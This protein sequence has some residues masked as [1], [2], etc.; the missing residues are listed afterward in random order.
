MALRLATAY[1]AIFFFVGLYLPF[2][3]VWLGHRGM[4]PSEVG[5]LLG[6][7]PW[8]R[9]IASP[10]AGRW[11]DRTGRGHRL[12]IVLALAV[13]LDLLLFQLSQGFWTLLLLTTILGLVHAPIIP[14]VDGIT[15]GAEAHGTLNY[16]RVR[17]WGSVAF[18]AASWI[19]G[20]LLELH[21]EEIIVWLMVSAAVLTMLASSALPAP[22]RNASDDTTPQQPSKTTASDFSPR[23]RAFI[24]FL[25][26][27]GLLHLSHAVLYA[28]GT[29]HWREAGL[30]DGIIG[31]LWAE[32]VIAE[33][34]LFAIAPRVLK[35]VSPR[36]LW[37]LAGVAGLVRWTVLGSTTTLL[38]IAVTQALHG[39]TFGALHL[40]A[41]AYLRQQVPD[42]A[43]GH[44]T[45]LYS[46]AA[47]GLALGIGLPVA[48]QLYQHV[49]GQAYWLM[50]ACSGLGLVL[51][52]MRP[53]AAK[54]G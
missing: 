7:S 12:V 1:S 34:L 20:E 27:A 49:G 10:I 11:A 32:S 53:T 43:R 2:W 50:S 9:V 47:A 17:L 16:S 33:I 18:I 52:F 42:A 54:A 15:L 37:M 45:T 51:A 4:S 19:G 25:V 14:L 26:I 23:S 5:L 24:S 28:F 38:W 22:I 41:M 31:L 21:G 40:G 39:L 48:G 30:D 6:V 3:P 46:A 29:H 36:T 44:A 8:T 13:G 35:G